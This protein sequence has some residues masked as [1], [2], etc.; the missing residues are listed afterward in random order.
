MGCT[1]KSSRESI[2][3]E[4]FTKRFKS[5]YFFA[6]KYRNVRLLKEQRIYAKEIEGRRY[7]IGDKLSYVKAIID[8]V[9]ER[10]DLKEEIEKYLGIKYESRRDNQES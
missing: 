5:L 4:V 2:W 3:W 8:F 6:E 7:D 10:Q 9:L 1:P